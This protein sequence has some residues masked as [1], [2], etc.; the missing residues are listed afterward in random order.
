[1]KCGNGSERVQHPFEL[2]GEGWQNWGLDP[3]QSCLPILR[4]AI[5]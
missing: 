5:A 1:M 3:Y 4:A 2:F